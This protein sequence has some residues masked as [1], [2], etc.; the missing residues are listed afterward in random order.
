VQIDL[1]A[2][3]ALV[4]IFGSVITGIVTV[5]VLVLTQKFE[6]KKLM[7]ARS[8]EIAAADERMEQA[9]KEIGE[10]RK[11]LGEQRDGPPSVSD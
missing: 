10:L 1:T 11:A 3:T 6:F 2:A 9:L 7:L 8:R 4:A 5:A